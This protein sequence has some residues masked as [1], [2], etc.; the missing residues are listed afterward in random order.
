MVCDGTMKT[1]NTTLG[2]KGHVG[3]RAWNERMSLLLL[4]TILLPVYPSSLLC[5]IFCLRS[6]P[7]LEGSLVV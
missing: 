4:L 7:C 1:V 5:G 6:E 2:E 3:A